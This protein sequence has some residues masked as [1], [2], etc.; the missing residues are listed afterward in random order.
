MFA[1]LAARSKVSNKY[2]I[3]LSDGR[4]HQLINVNFGGDFREMFICRG[5]GLSNVLHPKISRWVDRSAKLRKLPLP[6][7]R[8]RGALNWFVDNFQRM[9]RLEIVGQSRSDSAAG[10]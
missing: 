10:P 7:Q 1:A 5:A 6:S 3:R 4:G 2:I 8:S 9:A